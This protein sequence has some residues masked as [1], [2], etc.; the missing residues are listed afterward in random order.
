MALQPTISNPTQG[1]DD[2]KQQRGTAL[3][4]R[5]LLG[6]NS[7]ARK[8]KLNTMSRVTVKGAYV[9]GKKKGL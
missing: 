9:W 2:E 8:L 6:G 4:F 3:T 5:G 7:K 1:G